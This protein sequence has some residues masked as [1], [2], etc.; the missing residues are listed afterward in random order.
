MTKSRVGL[1]DSYTPAEVSIEDHWRAYNRSLYNS[2]R[3]KKGFWARGRD[4]VSVPK[5]YV[6]EFKEKSVVA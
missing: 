5:W 4:P 6:E 1:D 2:S 3:G